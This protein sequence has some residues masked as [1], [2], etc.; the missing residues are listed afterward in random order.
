MKMLDGN[1]IFKRQHNK[2]A[3]GPEILGRLQLENGSGNCWPTP[4]T[5]SL[6]V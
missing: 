1:V 4:Q 6:N 5:A 3:A 2:C